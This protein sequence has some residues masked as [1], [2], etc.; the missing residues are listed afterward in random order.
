MSTA[1]SIRPKD[2]LDFFTM[3]FPNGLLE[4][5]RAIHDQIAC[6]AFGL[7]ERR[8]GNGGNALDD[9]LQAESKVLE[10]VPVSI[11]N[12]KDH[13]KVMAEVPGFALNELKVHIDG[14]ELHICGKSETRTEKADKKSGNQ[15]VSISSRKI[16]C[17]I[18]LPAAVKPNEGAAALDKGVLTLTL[19]KSEQDKEITVKAARTIA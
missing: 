13:V 1:L 11:V 5:M 9:W 16:C 7:F 10:P 14:H 12:E 18:A 15:E 3:N 4:E 17:S 6:E 19:P 2:N 8:N